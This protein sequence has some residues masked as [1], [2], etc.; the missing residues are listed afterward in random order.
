MG[1]K[2][3]KSIDTAFLAQPAID[4]DLKNIQIPFK[5]KDYIVVVANNLT[6]GHLTFKSIESKILDSIYLDVL[7]MLTNKNIVFLP[8]L[9]AN[10]NDKNYFQYLINSLD[11]DLR[12]NIHIVDENYSS[13]I[14]QSIIKKSSFVI[15]ARYHSIVFS[16]N[17]NIPF[18]CLSYENKMKN[19]L[20]ILSF[21][22][23]GIDLTKLTKENNIDSLKNEIFTQLKILLD[24]SFII[25]N[26]QSK[27]IAENC[28]NTFQNTFLIKNNRD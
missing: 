12:E 19:T 2:Y 15:G 17:N 27:Q 14:Q 1:L 7:K 18:L 26:K 10:G 16:I 9:F 22:N 8:Q 23:Y 6:A 3:I 25:D 28:F 4:I 21:S 13:D 5:E 24:K 20:E 11:R